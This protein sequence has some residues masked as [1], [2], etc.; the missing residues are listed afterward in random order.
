MN[1]YI[2][3][4]FSLD[5]RHDVFDPAIRNVSILWVI[6]FRGLGPFQMS[7]VNVTIGVSNRG[8]QHVVGDLERVENGDYLRS[9]FFEK[10]LGGVI[11]KALSTFLEVTRIVSAAFTLLEESDSQQDAQIEH[12]SL[13]FWTFDLCF[14]LRSIDLERNILEMELCHFDRIDSENKVGLLLLRKF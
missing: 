10:D 5:D 4:Q 2:S 8:H 14:N 1:Q 11:E 7:L 13:Q 12:M 6:K 3:S 9:E